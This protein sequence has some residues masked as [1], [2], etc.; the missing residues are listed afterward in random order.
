MLNQTIKIF[1]WFSSTQVFS[2]TNPLLV[3]KTKKKLTIK[4]CSALPPCSRHA[5]PVFS[6]QYN[7]C[8]KHSSSS[9][10]LSHQFSPDHLSPAFQS[11]SVS[12]SN[13]RVCGCC[14]S[15]WFQQS[16]SVTTTTASSERKKEQEKRLRW[17][18]MALWSAILQSTVNLSSNLG[19]SRTVMVL[20]LVKS[21]KE[22]P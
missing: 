6:S 21:L 18:E 1:I 4:F 10:P 14:F 12:E 22:K 8:L 3:A 7:L 15:Q 5:L 11:N 9:I 16:G 2:S 17:K 13:E 20:L 19:T